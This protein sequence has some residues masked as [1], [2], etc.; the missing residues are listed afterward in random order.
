M[1]RTARDLVLLLRFRS[2][3]VRSCALVIISFSSD[4]LLIRAAVH[5][6]LFFRLDCSFHLPIRFRLPA[7]TP[8]GDSLDTHVQEKE[9]VFACEMEY[10]HATFGDWI[11]TNSLRCP[12]PKLHPRRRTARFS[13]VQA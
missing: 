10:A 11:G 12:S 1:R 3:L 6:C 5:G 9:D 7:R 13:A 8:T 2:I 4:P